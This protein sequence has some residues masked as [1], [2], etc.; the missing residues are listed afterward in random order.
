MSELS[1]STIL[2]LHALQSMM[3]KGAAVSAGEIS[4][5]SGF[6][7]AQIRS[8][9]AKL[10]SEGMI[11]SRIGRGYVLTRSPGE[12]TLSQVMEAMDE[13]QTPTAPCG[14]DF[15]ACAARASCVLV[16]LCRGAAQRFQETARSFTLAELRR[17]PLDL[18]LCVVPGSRAG[19]S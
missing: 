15:E 7:T 10:Q 12:I 19:A 18:P 16:P 4:R 8:I 2:A 5:S 6:P 9:L 3:L 13:P 17:V 11:H 14:G 1:T